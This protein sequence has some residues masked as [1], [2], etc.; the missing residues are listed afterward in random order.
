MR[1]LLSGDILNIRNWLGATDKRHR[2]P[3]D[4]VRSTAHHEQDV[5]ARVNVTE[6]FEVIEYHTN[7]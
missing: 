6:Q 2:T 5:I 3:S 7:Q 4:D 1:R